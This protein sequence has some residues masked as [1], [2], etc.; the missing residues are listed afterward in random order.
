MGRKIDRDH[1]FRKF[2]RLDDLES[3]I[4]EEEERFTTFRSQYRRLH[5]TLAKYIAPM[6]P[7]LLIVQKGMGSSPYAPAS[8]VFGASSYLL[9]ACLSVSRGYDGIEELFKKMS[10]ITVRLKEYEYGAIES[11]L[12]KKL[13]DIFAYF[14][15]IFGQSRG[16]Y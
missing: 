10:N 8:T 11:S 12:N 15:E 14:L 1:T 13:T 9:Q 5:S 6:E 7:I 16:M 2:Q 4:E 3:A